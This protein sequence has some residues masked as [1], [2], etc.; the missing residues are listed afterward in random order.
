LLGKR[1]KKRELCW[2]PKQGRR[3]S[4]Q[5][6]IQLKHKRKGEGAKE[7][8]FP[9]IFQ[10]KRGKR[11]YDLAKKRRENSWKLFFPKSQCFRGTR[12]VKR[13]INNL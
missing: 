1:D 6:W 4:D 7:A 11:Q 2:N 9:E 8:S 3:I 13:G 12:K 10:E 5:R